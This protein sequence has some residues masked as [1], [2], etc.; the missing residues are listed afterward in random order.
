MILTVHLKCKRYLWLTALLAR[1]AWKTLENGMETVIV[2]VGRKG[3]LFANFRAQNKRVRSKG[4]SAR[5]ARF[6]RYFQESY[7]L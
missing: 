3:I 4:G 1:L 5:P 6:R 7:A 2:T